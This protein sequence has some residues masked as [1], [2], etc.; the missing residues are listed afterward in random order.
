MNLISFIHFF[1]RDFITTIKNYREVFPFIKKN[2]I[3]EGF[4]DYSW[5]IKF[6]LFLGA[7]L[8]LKFAGV[9]NEN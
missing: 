8:S 6:L 4:L 5:V 9:F 7:L 2:K 3:W 1:Q